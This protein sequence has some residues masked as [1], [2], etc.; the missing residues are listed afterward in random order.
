MSVLHT[1]GVY[2][3]TGVDGIHHDYF[4]HGLGPTEGTTLLCQRKK[5]KESHDG[6]TLYMLTDF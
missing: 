1:V 2:N 3:H 5:K 6:S 4:G